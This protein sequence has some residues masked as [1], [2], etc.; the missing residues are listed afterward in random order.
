MEIRGKTALVTG[1]SE[2]IGR[3]TALALARAGARVVAAAR[4]R[5]RLDAVVAEIEGAG[6]QALA[7]VADV[8]DDASVEAMASEAEE[9]FGGTDILVNN[10]GYGLTGPL[11][12]LEVDAVRRNFEVNVF[13]VLRCVRAVVPGMRRRGAG[14]VVNV[15]SVLGEPGADSATAM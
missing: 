14:H 1:A 4:R 8:A 9:R 3:A 6:G 13:G 10:A 12:E 2:G 7:V 11:S 15:S 5:D